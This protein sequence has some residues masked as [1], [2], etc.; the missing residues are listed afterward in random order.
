[1]IITKIE[2]QK[3]NKDRASIYIDEKFA[4]GVHINIV[5]DLHLKK[6]MEMTDELREEIL[7]LEEKKQGRLYGLKLINY[8]PRCEAEVRR[9]MAEKEYAPEIIEDTVEYLYE[10]NFLNDES[11][12]RY[13]IESKLNSNKY[14]LNRIKYQL[15][16]MGIDKA[17]INECIEDYKDE[18]N[19]YEVALELASKKLSSLEKDTKDA[20]Y[21]KVSGFLGRKG[22]S[23]EIIN[24]VL[25]ELLQ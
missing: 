3:K 25:R 8:R 24:K 9:K 15:S 20:K 10:Y 14:G 13:Y 6:G 22:Y 18:A 7:G 1:M 17:I 5:Y 19:E 16:S 12:T 11:F 21:R 23:F 4:F 2:L